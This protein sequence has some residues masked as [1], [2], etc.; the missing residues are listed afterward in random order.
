MQRLLSFAIMLFVCLA[1]MGQRLTPAEV[2]NPKTRCSQCWVSDANNVLSPDAKE[3]INAKING[4]NS[5]LG[6]EIAVAIVPAI[7]GDDEYDF[8]YQL[9]NRWGIGREGHNDGL[10]F[11]YVVDLRAMKFETGYALEGVLPDAYLDRLLNERIFPLMRTDEVDRAFA[12]AI[13]DI[14]QRL[15]T[16]EAKEE[17]LLN[18][19]SSKRVGI[20]ALAIYLTIAFV[21]LIIAAFEVFFAMKRLKGDN[22]TRYQMLQSMVDMLGILSFIFPIPLVF[23]YLYTR[24]LMKKQ[25]IRPVVCSHCGSSMR[26]LSEAEE[27]RYL[28]FGQQAEERVKSIDYDVWHCNVCEHNTILAYT[29][30]HT[31]YKKCPQCGAKTYLRVSDHIL[32]PPTTLT[33]GSGEHVYQCAH[34]G[35]NKAVRYIIPI[36]VAAASG[37][38]G[39][40]GFGGGFGGGMSGGGGAGG[41]F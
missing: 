7:E 27:D 39:G 16:D 22:N 26:R 9:F 13:D 34:C 6:V 18:T 15:T 5:T 1:I 37:G 19:S 11:L 3:Y 33:P 30:Q 38:K 41:R 14:V 28:N 35:F 23:M 2:A 32:T 8:A 40:S 36:I 17:L 4:L 29:A 31:K 10:L 12:I 20:T 25:R 21:L 24:S